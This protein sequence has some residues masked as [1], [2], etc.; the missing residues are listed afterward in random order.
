MKPFAIEPDDRAFALARDGVVLESSPSAV[1]DGSTGALPGADGWHTVRRLPTTTSTQHA[2]SVL[3]DAQP[4]ARALSLLAAELARRL[5]A[6]PPQAGERV[7]IAA[8]AGAG[9]YGLGALLGVARQLALPVD[10]FVDAAV[11]SVAALGGTGPAIVIELGLH[12]AAALARDRA[13]A[14]R[15]ET[16]GQRA[17][18]ARAAPRER[19]A[20]LPRDDDPVHRLRAGEPA[21]GLR[22]RGHLSARS[23]AARRC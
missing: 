11:V 21:G 4:S 23:A 10:G 22:R 13:A 18:A 17:H 20:G 19:A 3:R 14:A 9:R 8:P 12:H 15:A 2:G 7:W 16:G 1:S 5:A 6:H